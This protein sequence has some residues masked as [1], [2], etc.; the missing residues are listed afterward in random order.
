[1]A[2]SRRF[3]ARVVPWLSPSYKGLG[4]DFLSKDFFRMQLDTMFELADS[5][6]IWMPNGTAGA[7]PENHGW[8]EA[9]TE[10][11]SYLHHSTQFKIVSTTKP[12]YLDG[13]GTGFVRRT[14][15]FEN[16]AETAFAAAP[17]R[18]DSTGA[19]SLRDGGDDSGSDG[20][21]PGILPS[22][23]SHQQAVQQQASTPRAAA[24]SRVRAGE[25]VALGAHDRLA[26]QS[27]RV[28]RLTPKAP[29]SSKFVVTEP[30]LQEEDTKS[31]FDNL[32]RALR[33]LDGA[34]GKG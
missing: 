32:D 7:L 13:L 12:P 27:T 15:R 11:T 22:D 10:F 34:S 18:Y 30:T 9:L 20:N 1:M 5:V 19:N 33:L 2:E 25:I 17:Y 14:D 21:G 24:S 26:L 6:S 4:T 23:S 8:V 3:N 31:D 16:G 29:L 28:S